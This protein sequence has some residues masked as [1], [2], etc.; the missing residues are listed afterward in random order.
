MKKIFTPHWLFVIVIASLSLQAC[1]SLN[2]IPTATI[3]PS[4][5]N[6]PLFQDNK[7]IKGFFEENPLTVCSSTTDGWECVREMPE[8]G[9]WSLR[10]YSK[11][12]GDGEVYESEYMDFSG[13]NKDS[14]I[15]VLAGTTAIIFDETISN[16]V[17][18]WVVD[19]GLTRSLD[20]S[21]EVTSQEIN[22]VH[23]FLIVTDYSLSFSLCHGDWCARNE[24]AQPPAT[25]TPTEEKTT[26]GNL[27]FNLPPGW[28]QPDEIHISSFCPY[29]THQPLATI[30]FSPID[31]APESPRDAIVDFIKGFEQAGFQ[32]LDF[33][34][35]SNI[36]PVEEEPVVM[37]KVVM[38]HPD[39]QQPPNPDL[40]ASFTHNTQYYLI[41]G[42]L[43]NAA[44]E[45]DFQYLYDS[46]MGLLEGMSFVP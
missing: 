43:V 34:Y 39:F 20:N 15:E 40:V 13:L 38:V 6:T 1:T 45:D 23:V 12:T 4:P 31:G 35:L 42:S 36:P 14:F 18:D 44:E 8:M 7:S 16:A 10:Y 33:E 37:A 19:D 29:F 25:P 28:C 11:S 21:T 27:S 32:V 46:M 24:S 30:E 2:P 22:G 41:W 17:V 3:T 5:T 26:I 9:T